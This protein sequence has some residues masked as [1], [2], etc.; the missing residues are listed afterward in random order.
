MET[1]SEGELESTKHDDF[2]NHL[3]CEMKTPIHRCPPN[4]DI[5]SFETELASTSSI[6]ANEMVDQPNFNQASSKHKL[7]PSE[8]QKDNKKLKGT[9]LTFA[10]EVD[11]HVSE[12]VICDVFVDLEFST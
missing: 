8:P 2:G 4:D 5:A 1:T 12:D 3:L 11:D 10:H 6:K 7:S 9:P